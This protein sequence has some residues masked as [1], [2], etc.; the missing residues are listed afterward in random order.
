MKSARLAKLQNATDRQAGEI[1]RIMPKAGGGYLAAG[2]DPD[3]SPFEIIAYVA[4]IPQSVRTAG[5]AANSGHN[6]Q[7]R[8]TADTIKF[9]TSALPYLLRAND[10]VELLQREGRPTF[11]ISRT[12]PF[13]TNRTVGFMVPVA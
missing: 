1:V 4:M 2:I 7:I 9:A 13:G 8:A 12:A 3:R 6:A 11:R 5:N 10:E